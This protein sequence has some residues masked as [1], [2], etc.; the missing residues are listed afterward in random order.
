MSIIYEDGTDQYVVFRATATDYTAFT[1]ENDGDVLPSAIV[2]FSEYKQDHVSIESPTVTWDATVGA[3]K[4]VIPAANIT[5]I[6]TAW[7]TI[8]A[9]DMVPVSIELTVSSTTGYPTVTEISDGVLAA[10]Y[11]TGRT[12]TDLYKL[13]EIMVLGTVSG[14]AN[15]TGTNITFT[16]ADGSYVTFAVDGNGNRIFSTYSFA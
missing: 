14:L 9:T 12:I 2:V 8:S 11:R 6:G 7:L 16:S 1:G 3:W 15:G 5:Q 10:N 13:I 4:A